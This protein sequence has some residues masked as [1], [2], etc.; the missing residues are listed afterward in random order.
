MP[1]TQAEP[2]PST[3]PSF[4]VV[5]LPGLDGTGLLFAPLTAA[6]PTN[7]R[8]AVVRYPVDRVMSYEELATDVAGHL[9]QGERFVLL[10]ESFGGPLALLLA[11]RRPAGLVGVILCATFVTSPR[12]WVGP[13]LRPFAKPW[14]FRL[15]PAYKRA[16]PGAWAA[17]AEVSRLVRPDVIASRVR[18]V[19]SVDVRQQ[20]SG[21]PVPILYLRAARDRL[22]P[23]ANLHRIQ[24]LRPDVS[25][26]NLP[27]PH[28]VLQRRP[29][30]S[31]A[32]IARFA[33]SLAD[34]P[35]PGW[36]NLMPA[37]RRADIM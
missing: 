35:A 23:A 3:I 32:A 16:T 13:L 33:G 8:P 27:S 1:T 17:A 9:P 31:A 25:A 5:L 18:M 21:C 2:A 19:L 14:P 11:A 4:T 6:L 26:V 28:Q 15:Y 36:C 12:P 10:G 30:E 37:R 29:T 24:Q 20:L 7:V 22:V 34:D